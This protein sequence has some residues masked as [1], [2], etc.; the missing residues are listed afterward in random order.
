MPWP[1]IG[2]TQYHAQLGLPDKVVHVQSNGWLSG[3]NDKDLEP[4]NLLNVLVVINHPL[5][6]KSYVVTPT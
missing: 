3:I 1:E 2:A 5:R 6:Y 4:L